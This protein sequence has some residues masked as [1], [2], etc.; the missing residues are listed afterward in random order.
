MYLK[1][2]THTL[3]GLCQLL[4]MHRECSIMELW[5]ESLNVLHLNFKLFQEREKTRNAIMVIKNS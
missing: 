5:K 3:F 1:K 4:H 2:H